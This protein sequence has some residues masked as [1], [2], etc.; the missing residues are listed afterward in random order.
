[1]PP[2]LFLWQLVPI[3]RELP[4]YRSKSKDRYC[5]ESF[6]SQRESSDLEKIGK[7]KTDGK[8]FEQIITLLHSY[9]CDA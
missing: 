5:L 1:M 9:L 4:S 7:K 6:R 8:I 3:I 2:T